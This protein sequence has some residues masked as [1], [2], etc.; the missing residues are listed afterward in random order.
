MKKIIKSQ[1]LGKQTKSSKKVSLIQPIEIP[2]LKYDEKGLIPVIV[3]DWEKR[4]VLMVA[5]MNKESLE[6]TL[7]EGR[8]CFWSR[9]RQELW[10]KGDTS[11][12][13]Q[14]VKH[15]FYDCDKDTL[16]IEV[17]QLGGKACHTGNRSCFFKKIV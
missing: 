9:S 16:L 8:T 11:G 10:R 17:D 2:Q 14:M 1:K 7:K 3:Q 12:C 6:I 5:W 13:V 15:I 4:D